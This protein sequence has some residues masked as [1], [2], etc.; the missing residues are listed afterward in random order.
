MKIT[1]RILKFISSFIRREKENYISKKFYHRSLVLAEE[2][3]KK[4]KITVLFILHEL[5]KWKTESLYKAMSEH[6][7]FEPVIGVVSQVN[8]YPSEVVKKITILENYL[9]EKKYNFLELASSK[10]VNDRVKPD[11]VFYQEAGFLADLNASLHFK[12]FKNCVLC[13]IPYGLIGT[14]YDT[15]HETAIHKALWQLYVENDLNME[16]QRRYSSLHGRSAIITGHTM[17]DSLMAPPSPHNPWKKQSTEKMKIIWAPHHTI[18][19]I[20]DALHF[21]AFLNMADWMIEIAENTKDSVQWAFK[22]H[23]VLKRNLQLIWGQEKTEEYYNK[24]ATM[25]NTQLEEGEYMD[26]F[27]YSDAIV[28]ES[29]SFTVEYL[30]MKKPCMYMDNGMVHDYN[31]FGQMAHDQYYIG[32]TREDVEKFIQNVIDGIDPRKEEREAFYNKYL[33]PPNNR[34]ASENIIAAILGEPPYDKK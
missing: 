4:D 33:L 29:G 19:A 26:L 34:T 12:N 25:E 30:Y 28:H 10:D 15:S 7:R 16:H 20:K 9:T 6:P 32:K 27:K 13:Y 8:D 31:K 17:S 23:P 5:P 2:I 1:E 18:G 22:P 21:G 24:W 11:I 14:C 3:R